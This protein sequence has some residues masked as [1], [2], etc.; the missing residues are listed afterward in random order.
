MR[1][2][3]ECATMHALVLVYSVYV[4]TTSTPTP[5]CGRG[6]RHVFVVYSVSRLLF[7]QRI[8]QCENNNLHNRERCVPVSSSATYIIY[9]YIHIAH[10][11]L[12]ALKWM[13]GILTWF[14]HTWI[15]W[16]NVWNNLIAYLDGYSC[17]LRIRHGYFDNDYG[18][19]NDDDDDDRRHY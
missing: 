18:D 2:H 5:P 16:I 12:N 14:Q 10:R 19:D 15:N 13:R 8:L 11:T 1:A 3:E 7:I 4:Y 9:L 17:A 6:R